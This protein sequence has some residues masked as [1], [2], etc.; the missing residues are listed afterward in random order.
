MA[1]YTLVYRGGRAPETPEEGEQ[2][3]AAW[4]AWY[5]TLGA[6]VSDG[7]APFGPSMSVSPG[8]DVTEGAPSELTGYTILAADDL[9]AATALAGG[10][11]VL[12]AGGAVGVYERIDMEM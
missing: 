1:K 7:G 9:A 6:A 12:S 4:M 3:M 5:G 2:V 8:G 11:P 10:C